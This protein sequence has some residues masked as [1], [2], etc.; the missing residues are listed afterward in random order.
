MFDRLK[1][2]LSKPVTIWVYG[3]SLSLLE[4]MSRQ[5]EERSLPTYTDLETAVKALGALVQYAEFRRG[6]NLNPKL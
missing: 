1:Q 4:E 3:T 2:R 5:L 6:L